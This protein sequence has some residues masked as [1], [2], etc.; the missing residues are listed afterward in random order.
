M[1]VLNGNARRALVAEV[2]FLSV[3]NCFYTN[4]ADTQVKQKII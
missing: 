1:C 3:T 2:L 4:V